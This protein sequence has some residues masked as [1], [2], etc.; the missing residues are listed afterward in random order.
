MNNYVKR[1]MPSVV[2]ENDTFKNLY[3]VQ[4][5]EISTINS[6]VKGIYNNTTI[7]NS[8]IK[9]VKKWEK[10]LEIKNN[11]SADLETRKNICLN[12]LLY[13]PPFTRQRLT[14]ILT[15]I[16]GEGNFIFTIY[17]ENYSI[18][19]DVNTTNPIQYLKFSE[20]IRNTIPANMHL[21]FSIQYTYL[22][23]NRNFTYNKIEEN[24]LTYGDLSQYAIIE[25]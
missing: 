25:E 3:D 18:I 5:Q 7:N 2:S 8:D 16:W 19:I 24:K 12:R 20:D 9:G 14:D 1:F 15:N 13:R 11:S 23:L 4:N 17:P 6:E 10:L 21:I 22:Y